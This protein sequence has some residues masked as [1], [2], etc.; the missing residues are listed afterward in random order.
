[1]ASWQWRNLQLER[2]SYGCI[3]RLKGPKGATGDLFASAETHGQQAARGTPT[4]GGLWQLKTAIVPTQ[5]GVDTLV[6]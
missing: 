2:F 4:K 5:S 1:V 6:R 3:P